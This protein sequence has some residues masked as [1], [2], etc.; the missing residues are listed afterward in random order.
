ERGAG[1]GGCAARPAHRQ[2]CD[3]GAA[4]GENGWPAARRRERGGGEPRLGRGALLGLLIGRI[5]IRA[6]LSVNTAGLPRVGENGVQV[7]LDWR[8][9]AFT[10][11]AA[12]ATGILVGVIPAFQSL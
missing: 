3:Q 1:D 2:G 10:M 9:L 7:S 4:V 12:L 11:S 6:L 5:A 8:V